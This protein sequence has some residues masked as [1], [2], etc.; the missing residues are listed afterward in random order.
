MINTKSL[1]CFLCAAEEMNFSKAAERLYMSQQSLSNHIKRLETAYGTEL[2]ERSPH[3]KLTLAGEHMLLHAQNILNSEQQMEMDFMDISSKQR[4]KLSVGTSRTR[5]MSFFPHI[6]RDYH[7]RF[8]N[9]DIFLHETRSAKMEAALMDGVIDLYVGINA[10]YNRM[11]DTHP[12]IRERQYCLLSL[13]LLKQYFPSEWEDILAAC[14]KGLSV[15]F[16]LTFLRMPFIMLPV[17]NH[18]RNRLNFVLRQ[19][20]VVPNCIFETQDQYLILQLCRSGFGVGFVSQAFLF[21]FKDIALKDPSLCIIPVVID[22]MDVNID[23]VTLAG[24]HHPQY[25]Q[26]FIDTTEDFF[27]RCSQEFRDETHDDASP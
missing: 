12:L 17:G 22:S 1:Q 7:P 26:S 25:L 6:I 4:R 8:P 15:E 27:H 9:I 16:L 23:L 11:L 19:H 13:P 14:R 24:Q 3:L 18:I 2:F 10:T 5:S 21:A 20:S